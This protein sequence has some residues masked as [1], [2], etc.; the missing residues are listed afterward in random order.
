MVASISC[1]LPIPGL[2]HSL[3]GVRKQYRNG[4]KTES[5]SIAPPTR[6]SNLLDRY[7][8]AGI[9]SAIS[10]RRAEWL[11]DFKCE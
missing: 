4:S 6:A 8:R 5:K 9:S 7:T 11:T 3:W 2:G 10:K 1:E